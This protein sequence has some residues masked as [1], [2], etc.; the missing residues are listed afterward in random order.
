MALSKAQKEAVMHKDGP[1]I[2]LAGPGSGKTTVI[3]RRTQF[4][5]QHYGIAPMNILVVT[6]TKAAA[7]EMKER[8]LGLCGE[9][10]THVRFGTFHSVFFEI[11][12]YAYHFTAANIAGE[13]KKYALLK[14]IV[15]RMELEIDDEAEFIRDLVQEISLVKC[16]RISLEHYYSTSVPEEIFRKIYGSYQR[17]M[18]QENLLDYDDIMVYTW[19]LL[20]QRPDILSGWQK[21][22]QY[23]LIDEFQDINKLQYDI[24]RLLAK[25]QNNLFVVGDD[26]QSIYRFRGA[27]PELMLNFSKEYPDAVQII[28]DINFRCPENIVHTASRVIGRN[29]VRFEKVIKGKRAQGEQ[30]EYAMFPSQTQESLA[31]IKKIQEYREAG[32][33]YQDMAVLYRSHTEARVPSQKL[34][35]YNI[36]FRMRD[37]VPN[38]YE[39]WIAR[40]VIAYLNAAMGNRE[41]KTMLQ[42]INRPKRYISREC[43]DEPLVDFENLRKYY[44]DKYWMIE[45]IDKM[46]ND[47]RVLS[48]MDPYT[49]V[50]YLRHGIGYE[51]YLKEYA[52]FRRMNPEDLYEVLDQ[53]QESAKGSKTHEEWFGKMEEYTR[54][55]RTQAKGQGR[56]EHAVTLTTFH[57]AK[58]LEFPI[59]FLIDINEGI[60]PYK[61]AVLVSDI[62]EER[63][64][65]YVGLTRAK[66]RLHIYY[67]KEKY[68]KSVKPSPFL[69]GLLP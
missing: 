63:R 49:A 31:V 36:P 66:E 23:I 43:L 10:Y 29:T 64:M 51:E 30:I 67:V 44:D 45:K 40:N 50:N 41:R 14:E 5:I 17:K 28:L 18:E 55:L 8:F 47:L 65:F 53:L 42:I 48:R 33:Q 24:V 46:E 38:L 37:V 21:R 1:A 22:Y 61:K 19:E 20:S 2:I 27:K 39:H 11:L 3:T 59:V 60:L 52:E 6:F 34:L 16:E 4:L 57:G 35:E 32:Y 13:E 68:G 25:P 62:E 69:T 12:K 7:T 26:D 56:N 54:M 9:S 58:G 15:G